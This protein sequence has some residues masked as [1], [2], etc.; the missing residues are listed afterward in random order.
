MANTPYYL[1]LIII[2]Y[3]IHFKTFHN[4]NFNALGIVKKTTSINVV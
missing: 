1:T 3:K 4:V 2:N